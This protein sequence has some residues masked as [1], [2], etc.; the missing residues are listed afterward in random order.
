MK[1]VDTFSCI[2]GM[3]RLYYKQKIEDSYKEDSY[4]NGVMRVLYSLNTCVNEIYVVC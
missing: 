2:E 1:Y 3:L 4:I